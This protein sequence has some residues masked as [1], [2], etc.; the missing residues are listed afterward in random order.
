MAQRPAGVRAFTQALRGSAL[1]LER[2]RAFDRP[3]LFISGGRSAPHNYLPS[4]T[5]LAPVLPDFAHETYPAL[6]HF[7]PPY[8]AEAEQFAARLK[9]LWARAEA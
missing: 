8:W 6:D 1:D 7:T 3:V 9:R 5:R 2:L 4:L